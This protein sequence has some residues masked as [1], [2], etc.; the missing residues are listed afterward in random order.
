M[1]DGEQIP[2]VRDFPGIPD[3]LSVRVGPRHYLFERDHNTGEWLYVRNIP[4]E[5][6]DDDE[7]EP[8]PFD[9]SEWR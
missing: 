8:K 9:P 3:E 6:P 4:A 5:F 2:E 1:S 7:D